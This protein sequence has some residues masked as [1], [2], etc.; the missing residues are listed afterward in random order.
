MNPHIKL[1]L[2]LFNEFLLSLLVTTCL[3]IYCLK[4]FETFPWL[5]FICAPIGLAIIMACWEHKKNQWIIFILGL[6]FTTVLWSI[7]FNWSSFF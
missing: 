5:P 7:V 1:E 4:S 2:S 6:L 3:G